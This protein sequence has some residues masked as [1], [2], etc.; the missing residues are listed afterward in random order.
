MNVFSESLM[1]V[2]LMLAVW[3][4]CWCWCFICCVIYLSE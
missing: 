3:L 2:C 4:V 1:L